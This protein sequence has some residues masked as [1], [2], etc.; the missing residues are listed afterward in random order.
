MAPRNINDLNENYRRY[1][2]P[3]FANFRK[4]HNLSNVWC[5]L[6]ATSRLHSFADDLDI[7]TTHD[8]DI[9]NSSV[10]SLMCVPAIFTDSEVCVDA[11]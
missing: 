1:N 9:Q 11:C 5:G 7:S 2:F 6:P 4:F 10:V 3:A 8:S